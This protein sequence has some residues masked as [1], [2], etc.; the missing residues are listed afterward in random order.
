MA[1]MLVVPTR[2]EAL[3]F[4]LKA[5]AHRAVRR[6]RDVM[7]RDV[8]ATRGEALAT[9]AIVAEVRQPLRTN[10]TP[11]E[12]WL[13]NGK[14]QNLRVAARALDGC[15][16]GAGQTFSFWRAIGRPL[17]R[18]GFVEGRELR[19][20]CII[21]SVGGGLCQ[22]SNALYQAALEA[23]LEIVE[24]H[25]HSRIIPGSAAAA[26]RD[27][28]VFWNYVDLRFRA[29][30]SFRVEA[31][32][33]RDELVVRIRGTEVAG[34]RGRE[35]GTSSLLRDS[36]TPRPL[37]PHPENCGTCGVDDCFRHSPTRAETNRTAFLVDDYWPELDDWIAGQRREGDELALPITKYAWNT[38]G[39]ARV[40]QQPLLT[41]ARSLASR[42][43]A[44]AGAERQRALLHFDESMARA[45]GSTI[46]S[47][48]DHVVVSLSLL[49]FL[50]RAGILGGRSFDI[51]ANR[52]PLSMIHAQLDAARALHPDSPTLGDFRADA[53][54]LADE[55]E[56]LAACRTLVTPHRGVAARFGE[57][58]TL[59]DWHMPPANGTR[60]GSGIVFPAS[61]LG[62]EGAYEV[63]E[64]IRALN[65]RLTITGPVLE[66]GGFWQGLD[67]A[68]G[69]L[70]GAAV[71]ILPSFVASR[72]RRLLAALAA[73]IPVI[74]SRACGL[75][76][77]AGVTTI[78]AGDAG[79]LADALTK[80]L[81]RSVDAR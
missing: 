10:D 76:G 78:E 5:I 3:R 49:P 77:I 8:A 60:P 6:W 67:V 12:Q 81:R 39:F 80:E 33:T 19:E 14:I 16:V 58:A 18:R 25:G 46:A 29:G 65:V 55:E 45:L 73:G 37:D 38:Q 71:A 36:A 34:T 22:L 59:V 42:R 48:V 68:A 72:P 47:D 13:Q 21:A 31:G 32:L 62:R 4:E 9:A 56:A 26:S 50:W 74:A 27:A 57:R 28:T 23:G 75:E 53:R 70:D 63:R 35:V 66:A 11:G 17:R 54:L 24:R 52:L 43:L 30:F 69:N 1:D 2:L 51:L 64:A 40:T 79:A 7:D 15:E 20:G 44:H 41:I 61:T